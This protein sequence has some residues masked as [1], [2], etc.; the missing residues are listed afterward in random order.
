VEGGWVGPAKSKGGGPEW[1][2]SFFN[3]FLFSLLPST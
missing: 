3:F 2:F 1:G